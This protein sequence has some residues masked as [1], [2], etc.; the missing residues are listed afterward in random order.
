LKRGTRHA[1]HLYAILVDKDACGRSREEFA[2]ALAERGVSTSVHFRALH[3][4]PFYAER[5]RLRR[6]M[7]PNAERMSDHTLS[8]PLSA[9][10]T[11]E[12]VDRV[13]RSGH[14]GL[15]LK[16]CVLFRAAADLE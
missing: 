12:E 2:A 15:P 16:Q 6:G 10:M 11:D 4:H 5:F 13:V 14:R 3:L 7:F 8:L 9:A 1:R